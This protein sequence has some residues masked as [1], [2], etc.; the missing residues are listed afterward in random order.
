MMAD[1]LYYLDVILLFVVK[2]RLS[3]KSDKTRG[4]YIN[5]TQQRE[6]VELNVVID[7]RHGAAEVGAQNREERG[8]LIG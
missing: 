1:H 6:R 7:M 4:K 5:H 8:D 2:N 3:K